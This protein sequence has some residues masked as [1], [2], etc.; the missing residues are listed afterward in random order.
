MFPATKT[1]EEGLIP[2]K[3]IRSSTRPAVGA[4]SKT[5]R[6][7]RIMVRVI[8]R[9]MIRKKKTLNRTEA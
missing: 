9:V 6:V 5:W 1:D 3:I 4:V 2:L 8:I 7:T